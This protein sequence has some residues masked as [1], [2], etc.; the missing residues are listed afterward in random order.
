[1]LLLAGC[2]RSEP[3]EVPTPPTTAVPEGSPISFLA[4]NWVFQLQPAGD[5]PAAK[6][7]DAAVVWR[8]VLSGLARDPATPDVLRRVFGGWPARFETLESG[9]AT[10]Q[11]LQA[12]PQGDSVIVLRA[13]DQGSETDG[14]GQPRLLVAYGYA[15]RMP[16]GSRASGALVPEPD[17]VPNSPQGPPEPGEAFVL[18]AQEYLLRHHPEWRLVSPLPESNI[19]TEADPGAR[20]AWLDRRIA[21]HADRFRATYGVPILK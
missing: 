12:L 14:A 2:A 8:G 13:A 4:L 20:R 7:S 9:E 21:E 5:D 17:S 16:R 10:D 3:T 18:L 19:P 6:A 15:A 1:L 11:S